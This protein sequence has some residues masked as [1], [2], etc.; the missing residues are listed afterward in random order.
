MPAGRLRLERQPQSPLGCFDA[1]VA[2]RRVIVDNAVR[3]LQLAA[4]AL[5]A[6]VAILISEVHELSGLGGT[7]GGSTAG[8][9]A[10]GRDAHPGSRC[11]CA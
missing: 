8:G 4:A 9:T 2:A 3:G 11:T 6:H 1:R 5:G 7:A 10:G